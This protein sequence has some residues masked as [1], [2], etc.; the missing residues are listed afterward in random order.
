MPSILAKRQKCGKPTCRC[1]EGHLHGPY[2]WLVTYH[3][4]KSSDRRAGKYSWLY[5][6]RYAEKAWD[7]LQTIEPR[8]SQKF[9]FSNL[10]D[11]LQGIKVDVDSPSDVSSTVTL[12]TIPEE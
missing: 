10:V 6:G 1:S 4:S 8:F 9:E 5:L 7:K 12:L 2:L 3:S 11:K